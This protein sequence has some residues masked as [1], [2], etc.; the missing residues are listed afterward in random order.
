MCRNCIKI[1]V[2]DT[3]EFRFVQFGQAVRLRHELRRHFHGQDR[4]VVEDSELL[5][6]GRRKHRL[7]AQ[8][9]VFEVLR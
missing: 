8:Y 4:N 5:R 7:R 3:A 9:F 2:A 6:L 1:L